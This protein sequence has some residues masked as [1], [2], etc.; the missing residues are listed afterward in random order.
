MHCLL[1]LLFRSHILCA[2][3]YQPY[4]HH[5]NCHAITR[6]KDLRFAMMDNVTTAKYPRFT[7]GF[8]CAGM[9]RELFWQS[10]EYSANMPEFS[11]IFTHGIHSVRNGRHPLSFS[12]SLHHHVLQHASL[13]I[14]CTL[15][16]TVS[17]PEQVPFSFV[18]NAMSFS[19]IMTN[20]KSATCVE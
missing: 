14:H 4:H 2:P 7:S 11:P 19:Y 9:F 13:V 6:W 15:T 8:I 12:M 10:D 16:L 5:D 20:W 1:C 17:L 18:A 3:S